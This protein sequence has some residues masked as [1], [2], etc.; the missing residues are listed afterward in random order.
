MASRPTDGRIFRA[1]G[2]LADADDASTESLM[3]AALRLR[4]TD[5]D[6]HAWMVDRAASRGDFTDAVAHADAILRVAPAHAKSIFPILQH[7]MED[8][9]TVD[10]FVAT[11]DKSP[12]WRLSFIEFIARSPNEKPLY[13]LARII[14]ALHN[15]PAAVGMD[16][17]RSVINR[18]VQRR[19]FE[20]AYLLWRSLLPAQQ[21]I[22]NIL[23][24]GNFG[25][26]PSGAAFDWTLHSAPGALASID[27]DG[28]S[29]PK[30]LHIRFDNRPVTEIGASQTLL[31]QPG[32]YRLTGRSRLDD[33]HSAQGL[34]WRILCLAETQQRIG[35]GPKLDGTKAWSDF[36]FDIDVPDLHCPAQR[37]QLA[38]RALARTEQT[39]SGAVWFDQLAVE[40]RNPR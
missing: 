24:N 10:A 16:D 17:A 1:L 4:P 3:R 7:W 22:S 30:A 33:L 29:H 26:L 34:E 35:T 27:R 19:D 9:S 38:T 5:V 12:S 31:L 21:N 13:P 23:Y 28:E 20:R 11:F 36:E 32:S 40:S 6:A 37:L 25:T 18:L 8:D 14:Q 15:S 39:V 2:Q